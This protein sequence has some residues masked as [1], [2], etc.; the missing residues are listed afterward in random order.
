MRAKITKLKQR[1]ARFAEILRAE[2]STPGNGDKKV[3]EQYLLGKVEGLK[4]A[5]DVLEGRE[6]EEKAS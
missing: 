4:E 5:I 2:G 6:I 3:R 1:H